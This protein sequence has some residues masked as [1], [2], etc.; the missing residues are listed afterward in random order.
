MRL[1]LPVKLGILAVVA[2]GALAGG[3]VANADTPNRYAHSSPAPAV[4]PAAQH[5][6]QQPVTS[7]QRPAK[8]AWTVDDYN[9]Y[10]EGYRLGQYEYHVTKPKPYYCKPGGRPGDVTGGP[11]VYNPHWAAGLHDACNEMPN[12][13]TK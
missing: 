1:N 12:R 11:D 13:Y 3:L 4:A 2:T 8:K 9:A 7:T 10:Q 5:S 6:G